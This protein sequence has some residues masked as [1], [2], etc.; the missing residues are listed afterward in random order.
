M[1]TEHSKAGRQ[2]EPGTAGRSIV[3]REHIAS[4][5][6]IATPTSLAWAQVYNAGTLFLA[7]SLVH[8]VHDGKEKSVLSAAGKEL[9]NNIEAEY[10]SLET[11]GMAAIKKALMDAIAGLPAD[12]SLSL[13]AASLHKDSAFVFA[14]D[15]GTITIQRG[16][17]T[18]VVLAAKPDD[19]TL[20]SATGP[21]EHNDMF[22]LQTGQFTDL[23]DQKEVGAS[24]LHAT[25]QEAA[26]LFAKKLADKEEPGAACVLLEYSAPSGTEVEKVVE[27]RVE[28]PSTPPSTRRGRIHLISPARN[29]SQRDAGRPITPISPYL[30][31]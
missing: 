3:S 5:K 27:S 18:G 10:F 25:I 31:P 30:P 7:L 19:S 11:K 4:E 1:P 15:G 23:I 24:L 22:A 28:T 12:V 8:K 2:P 20:L 17:N 29:A 6:I 26:A 21:L 9:L 13:A 16:G 14:M